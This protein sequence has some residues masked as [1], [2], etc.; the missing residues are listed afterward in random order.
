VNSSITYHGSSIRH[1]AL[2]EKRLF[3]LAKPSDEQI[4]NIVAAQRS[5]PFSY[6][7]AGAT[8]DD[9]LPAG[10]TRDHNRISLGVGEATFRRAVVAM[11]R[12][13]MFN[14]AWM[15]LCW[16]DAPIAAGTTVALVAF[17]LGLWT[18]N[19]CRVVYIVDE[20]G[21]VLR[22]GFAYGTLPEHVARGEERFLIEWDR[23]DDSVYYSILAYSQPNQLL[24]R[25]G[26]PA[27]RMMQKRFAR[28]SKGA[29][30]RAVTM[31]DRR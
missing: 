26:Y 12:W 3:L 18:L 30:V 11:Q 23:A 9:T 1:Q 24:T 27:M 19:A 8:R 31:D 6:P 2:L 13:G 10:Y 5:A 17:S 29:M 21:P 25:L 28:A 15:Q 22:Y 16:P 7:F 20:D 14:F 4:R